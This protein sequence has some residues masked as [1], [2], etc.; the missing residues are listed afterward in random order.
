[1]SIF[2]VTLVDSR[3]IVLLH[4]ERTRLWHQMSLEDLLETK[5]DGDARASLQFLIEREHSANFVLWH[6]EDEARLPLASDA[7]IAAVKREIDRINQKRNDTAE[8]IDACLLAHLSDAGLQPRGEQHSE[9]P[10]M[11]IDRLSIL[12]LKHFHTVQ[13][14]ERADAPVGHRE[15]NAERLDALEQQRGDLA[16]CLD[17]L[18]TQVCAG[19]RYFRQYRQLKMYNDPELNPALYE[20]KPA[21]GR[22]T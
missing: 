11:M 3:A 2:L 9:T 8:D 19:E 20:A 7:R 4:D 5:P 1:M 12:S 14:M 21:S 15:R 10:G 13:E 6:A 17:R 22:K 18:W 16:R